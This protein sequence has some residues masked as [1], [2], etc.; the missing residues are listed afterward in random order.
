MNQ[1]KENFC[2]TFSYEFTWH[3]LFFLNMSSNLLRIYISQRQL[4]K[5]RT[6]WEKIGNMKKFKTQW[7]RTVKKKD[8]NKLF[9]SSLLHQYLLLAFLN[10]LEGWKTDLIS[11]E[12]PIL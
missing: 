11:V 4:P 1:L 3:L 2:S 8:R 9:K 5:Q 10:S 12:M 7:K 6:Y